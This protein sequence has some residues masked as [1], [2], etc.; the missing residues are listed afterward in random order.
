MSSRNRLVLPISLLLLVSLACSI[1]GL[2]GLFRGQ[3]GTPTPSPAEL[4]LLPPTLVE[5]IPAPGEELWPDG[6]ITLFFDQPMNQTLVEQAFSIEPSVEGLITWLDESTLQ[7]Q[8][9]APLA[10]SAT[11]LVTIGPAARSQEGLALAEPITLDITTAGPL[12]VTQVLPSP[13]AEEVDPGS[14]VT[15][16]FNRPVVPLQVTEGLPQPLSFEPAVDGQGEWIDTGIYVFRPDPGFPGGVSVTARLD[17][18]L[19]DLTGGT[20]A[21]PLTWSF[22][23]ALPRVV[24]IEPG[25]YI[26][27]IP[28]DTSIDITFNQAMNRAS[29]QAALVVMTSGSQPVAGDYSWNDVGT[30]LTFTPTDLLPYGTT[31]F[32]RVSTAALGA[33]GGSLEGEYRTA[34][35][36]VSTPEILRTDPQQGT[37]QSAYL[38]VQ[39]TFNS[40]MDQASILEGLQ[41]TPAVENL[42]TGWVEAEHIA[43]FYGDFLPSTAYTLSLSTA[44]QDVYGTS[45]AEPLL[46][47]FRT[48]PLPPEAN[49]SRYN[50]V[51][52]LTPDRPPVIDV[53]ARNIGSISF[54]LYRLTQDRFFAL[55]R[56]GEFA[57]E[58][59][60]APQGEL[61]R[62]WQE[63]VP[64][65]PNVTQTLSVALQSSPLQAGFYLVILDSPEDASH[66]LARLLI[67]RQVELVL[68]YS[69]SQTVVWA[70]D[71]STGQPLSGL[72]ISLLDETGNTITTGVTGGEGLL[73]LAY[74][75]RQDEELWAT[76]Y[77]T[78]GSPEAGSF[79]LTA[80]TWSE[81]ISPEASG[82]W[83]SLGEPSFAIDV[84]TER[85]LYR[86][87]QT[88]HIRGVLR[89]AQEAR[90]QLPDLAAV[91]LS[92]YDG[93]GQ[94][95]YSGEAPLSDYGTFNADVS[96]SQLA[97]LGIYS[98]QTEYGGASFEVGEYRKP[99]ISVAVE[100]S[101]SEV[102][103]GDPLTA[104]IQAEYYFG[105]PVANAQVEWVAWGN[106]ASLPWLE[107]AVD[108]FARAEGGVGP[109]GPW[110]IRLADGQGETGPDGSLD[111]TLP[112]TLEDGQPLE[113][114]VEATV[115]ESAGLP[116]TG[117]G[118]ATIH[119]ASFY[120]SLRP[121]HYVL[122]AGGEAVITVQATD[123]AGDPVT[124]RQVQ[125]SLERLTWQQLPDD[126]GNLVW[127]SQA[128]LVSS[129]TIMP[130]D[131]GTAQ[132]ALLIEAPGTYQVRA[133]GRDA[134]GRQASTRLSLWATGA[135]AV[136]WPQPAAERLA[137]V[138]DQVSYEP[139]QTASIL[140]PSPFGSP[141]EALVTIERSSVLSQQVI[142]IG[143]EQSLIQIPIDQSLAP[144]AYVSVV[145]VRPA[146][147]EAPA[148]IAAGTVELAV[149]A[150][151]Y[152]LQVS[153]T[154]DPALA[155]PDSSVTYTVQASDSTGQPVQAE[156]SLALT[157]LAALALSRPY[158]LSLFDTFYSYQALRVLTGASLAIAGEGGAPSPGAEGMGGGGGEAPGP[159]DEVR[160]EFPDTAYW[161]PSVV[162]D[163]NGQAQVSLTLPDSLTTW[164]MEARGIT[165]DT[166]VGEAVAETISTLEL[167][168]R[169]VTPRFFTAGD[170]ARV[171]A[172]VHNNTA[173]G[174]QVEVWLEAVG[175]EIA[176]PDRMTV[177]IPAGG[178]QRV[179]WTLTIQD[180]PGVDLTFH[181]SG[182]GLEDASKPT[183]GSASDGLLPVLR[184]T[185]PDTA[186]TSGVLTA[187]GEVIQAISLPR[188]YDATQGELRVVVDPSLGSAMNTA[189]QALEDYPYLSTEQ[190]VSRFLPNLAATRAM[191][192]LALTDPELEARLERTLHSGLETLASRQRSDGGWG[193]WSEGPSDVYLTAYV[194]YALTLAQQL[195]LGI[196]EGL[197]S[198]AIAY[199]Q[200]NLSVP[201]LSAEQPTLDREVFVLFALSTAGSSDLT[202]T[203]QM[204]EVSDGLSTWGKALLALTVKRVDP[205]N[206]TIPALLSDLNTAAVRSST[207]AHWE[208]AVVDR[209]NMGSPVRT[210]SH[211]LQTLLALDP[212]NPIIPDAVRWLLAARSPD[213]SWTSTHESA[214]ALLALTDWMRLS[215]GLQ[216]SF[217]YSVDLNRLP[218]AS[219]TATAGT[220]SPSQ[221]LT[222]PLG[223]LV[224]DVPNQLAVRRGEGTGTLAYTAHLTVYRPIEEVE[225]VSRGL[226]VTR[227]TFVYDGECGGIS[228]PCPAATS[229]T[230]GETILV[231]LTVVAPRAQY[232]LAVEDPFP[233]GMEP[234]DT[235]LQTS[236]TIGQP[237]ELQATDPL[238]GGWGWW[239]FSRAEIHDDH[240]ALF[241]DYLPAGTYQYTYL[242]HATLAGEYRV[243]PTRA[244]AFYFPEVYGHGAGSVF[245]IQPAP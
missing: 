33:G 31:V 81:G 84:Y 176:A 130:D 243:L 27:D 101:A 207:G 9:S 89:Q 215:G 193:W 226:T 236:P 40:P 152:R 124:G 107:Q 202:I 168:V 15:V 29:V 189:L 7:F 238:H 74:E 160:S 58:P 70:V 159:S 156:F 241:A 111:I 97:S 44:A 134:S 128:T 110:Y 187:A 19:T 219:G 210:T 51:L 174:L 50:A 224:A 112:T 205:A 64:S 173:N 91:P 46:L 109:G 61:V 223:Q 25:N 179:E 80:S 154:A 146:S 208:D 83:V 165:T 67:V 184:Y 214:W 199:L 96:L 26:S 117:R 166:L 158:A 138:P 68:K 178:Q 161:N 206:S 8:P 200:S 239:W 177:T 129:Q 220:Y 86:P 56:N 95:V 43:Y 221:V 102:G 85:P 28:R 148:A 235:S 231:R 18:S 49:F 230:V 183:V 157:D 55:A 59:P 170:A 78:C 106:P 213:G 191:R 72:T 63:P 204:A 35:N 141:V 69:A 182:G 108:W 10:R 47:T 232:Y 3:G 114:T 42:G 87:G 24:S 216:A 237:P 155:S 149:S 93:M 133:I 218:Q 228:L 190:I 115:T 100:P 12:E 30:V 196:D 180:V 6:A 65:Q 222:I 52:S 244:W 120:L 197:V 145:L 140:V 163:A 127:Q 188:R 142:Q 94:L 2:E 217:D 233:A 175:A 201:S 131:G 4:P 198:S 103:A 17:S 162:T 234:I 77:A 88:V 37:E 54:A 75:A 45:L 143:G 242:L 99:E 211:V 62:Q 66:R 121:D 135:G 151:A 20:L 48:A 169:P 36:V 16:V 71:L 39:I 11:Y 1:P 92:V 167:F 153:L 118:T 21:E 147:A 38:P 186:A 104:R 164:H 105:G 82:I 22:S 23:T 34:F 195:D 5:T 150:Q 76:V 119:P 229:A 13:G 139:G 227:D 126:Q 116:V 225:P 245:T 41:I 132:G 194:L 125:V 137:L 240:L 172:I 181:A 57:Y 113:V 123:W 209:W 136:V 203:Q 122:R 14:V 32:L 90:Y 53:R 73:M 192:E 144:N 79:G 171:A 98:V 185:A 60:A 212:S